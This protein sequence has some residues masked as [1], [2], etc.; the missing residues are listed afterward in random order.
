MKVILVGY[1]GSGKTTLGKLLAKEYRVPFVDLDKHIEEK[2]N[3]SVKDIFKIKGEIYF[4]KKEMLCLKKMLISDG[5]FILSLGGGTP[6]FGEN[7]E[8]ITTHSDLVFY[9]K[10]Q[11]KTLSER[12]RDEKNN[13]PLISHIRNEDLEDFI[14]KHLF[15]RNPYYLKAQYIVQ[16]DNLSIKESLEKI[17]EIIDSQGNSYSIIGFRQIKKEVG[18]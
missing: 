14:R 4:R 8:N 10:Y 3:M 7:M 15:E 17:K 16:M 13:R 1:M 2:E 12:L 5:N 18:L 9:L 11:P 6:C